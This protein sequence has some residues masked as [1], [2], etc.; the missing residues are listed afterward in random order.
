M[1]L[2]KQNFEANIK[3]GNILEMKYQIN[4]GFCYND[5]EIYEEKHLFAS[6][7]Q[8]KGLEEN[9]YLETKELVEFGNTKDD[10]IKILESGFE[11][12]GF[13]NE[14]LEKEVKTKKLDINKNFS[15]IQKMGKNKIDKNLIKS[16][17]IQNNL[18]SENN[19]SN[20][21]FQKPNF[22][23]SRKINVKNEKLL[24]K[25]ISP[26]SSI[27]ISQKNSKKIKFPKKKKSQKKKNLNKTEP[28]YFYIPEKSDGDY[29]IFRKHFGK[30]KERKKKKLNEKNI[31]K[32]NSFDNLDD[33]KK[34]R[35]ISINFKNDRISDISFISKNDKKS[36]NI[37][38]RKFS[39]LKKK[40]KKKILE[41]K[42]LKK[43]F[44][45][46]GTLLNKEIQGSLSNKKGYSM[47]Y[48]EKKDLKKNKDNYYY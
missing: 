16:D 35:S 31:F 37:K 22:F 40:N 47:V 45:N 28:N 5:L 11:K 26:I 43:N 27:K 18:I 20:E 3:N 25:S 24:K 21:K 6:T 48:K 36:E 2:K 41:K 32:N 12:I 19:F 4:C 46:K 15:F 13:E 8:E 23:Y 30:I 34:V 44:K 17:I 29:L 33:K 10:N 7:S 9:K 14:K 38:I 39:D 1:V 42:N